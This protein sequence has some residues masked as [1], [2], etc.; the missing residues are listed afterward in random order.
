MGA[1]ATCPPAS[2]PT[3]PCSRS[4]GGEAGRPPQA[5]RLRAP[6][7]PAARRLQE[8]DQPEGGGSHRQPCRL[9]P[10][11]LGKC[12]GDEPPG[13]ERAVVPQPPLRHAALAAGERPAVEGAL[14]DDD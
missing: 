3:S 8:R 5:E 12:V 14:V 2:A 6:L 9:E 10:A 1:T 11:A 13:V 7:A 4:G